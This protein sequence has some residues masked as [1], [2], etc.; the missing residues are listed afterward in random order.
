MMKKKNKLICMLIVI[1][2]LVS[3]L[4]ALAY[5]EGDSTDLSM[6]APEE[7][8]EPAGNVKSAGGQYAI[9]LYYNTSQGSVVAKV[10]GV[11]ATSADGGRSGLPYHHACLRL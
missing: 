1:A 8:T 11:E 2:L 6:D 7:I 4:P 3:L 5:A 10:D 9:N